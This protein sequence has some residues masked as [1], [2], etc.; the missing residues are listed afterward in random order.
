MPFLP[1]L[2]LSFRR[3]QEGIFCFLVLVGFNASRRASPSFALISTPA[4]G[5]LLRL[6]FPSRFDASRRASPSF[7][8]ISTQAGWGDHSPAPIL[9]SFDASR[10]ASPSF[11]LISTLVGGHPLLPPLSL[12]FRRQ[13]EGIPLLLPHSPRFRCRQEGI[14][15]ICLDFDTGRGVTLLLLS[16]DARRASPSFALISTLA[17]GHPPLPLLSLSFRCQQEGIPLL[18]PRSPQFRCRQ[19]GIPLIC[20]DFDT[21]HSPASVLLSFDARRACPS[22]LL[23]P[24]RFNAGRRASPFA[25]IST[26]AGKFSMLRLH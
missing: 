1:P 5:H 11:A 24:S 2:S 22:C 20:L 17:G 14:P 9:L 26:R 6:L 3:W 13:Q 18:L 4:G 16:F 12:L 7:A 10:R 25:S 23:F 19:E 21:D 15:L 8:S